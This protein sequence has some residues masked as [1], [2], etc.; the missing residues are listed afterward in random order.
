MRGPVREH[1]LVSR[2]GDESGITV[3]EVTITSAMIL[4]LMAAVLPILTNAFGTLT[5]QQSRADTTDQLQFAMQRIERDVRSGNVIDEPGTVDGAPGMELRVFTQLYGDPFR[6][7]QYRVS[8]GRLERRDRDPAASWPATWEV[9]AEGVGNATATPPVPAFTRSSDRQTLV[10]D[11]IMNRAEKTSAAVRVAS[12]VTAR[13]TK[14][15]DTPFAG[16][17]CP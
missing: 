2:T 12:S 14:S 8:T 15:Y 7:V 13:N 16:D 4:I 11:L 1:E 3:L 17:T 9:I 10:I 5:A 6:C